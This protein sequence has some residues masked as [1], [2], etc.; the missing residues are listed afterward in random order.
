MT[1]RSHVLRVVEEVWIAATPERVFR[2]LTE[3]AELVQWW[4]IP[5][6]YATTEAQVDVRVGGHYRLGGWSRGLGTFQVSG[7]YEVVEPPRR[8]AYTWVP[9]WDEDARNSRIEFVLEDQE[10]GTTLRLT[11]TGFRSSESRNAHATGW[12][13]VLEGLK[14]HVA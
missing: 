1:V 14:D 4:R 8:L 9:D 12:P 6:A 5:D 11:H 13:G 10:G 2:A 3:P 7:V